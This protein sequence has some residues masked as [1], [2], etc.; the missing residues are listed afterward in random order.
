[1]ELVICQVQPSD[2]LREQASDPASYLSPDMLM[3]G[4]R[5][6]LSVP[7]V[8]DSIQ[9]SHGGLWTVRSVT[10][11]ENPAAGPILVVD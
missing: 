9:D 3:I 11:P 4:E 7:R 8:G 2:R 10:W 6:F 5:K 1:M